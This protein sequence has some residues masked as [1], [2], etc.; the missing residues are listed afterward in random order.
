MIA[1]I[2]FCLRYVLFP[3]MLGPVNKHIDDPPFVAVDDDDDGEEG[4]EEER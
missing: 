2:A 1:M 3:P 4:E